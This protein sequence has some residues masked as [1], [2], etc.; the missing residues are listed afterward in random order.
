MKENLHSITKLIF[1]IKLI[2]QCLVYHYG[3]NNN[4]NNKRIQQLQNII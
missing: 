1:N 3:N 2:H 4:D